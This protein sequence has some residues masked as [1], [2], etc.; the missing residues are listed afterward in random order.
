MTN[1]SDI[2]AIAEDPWSSPYAT[3]DNY[4]VV[5]RFEDDETETRYVFDATGAQLALTKLANDIRRN[6]GVPM[7]LSVTNIY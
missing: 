6:P 3:K 2:D 5:Y 4:L 7:T 1:N